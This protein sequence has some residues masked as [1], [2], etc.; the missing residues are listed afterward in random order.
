MSPCGAAERHF[1]HKLGTTLHLD[2]PTPTTLAYCRISFAV[3][4]TLRRS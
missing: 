2:L 4:D 3:L 1:C